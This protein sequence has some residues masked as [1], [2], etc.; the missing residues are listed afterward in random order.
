MRPATRW[1]A[2][3]RHWSARISGTPAEIAASIRAYGEQG[4]SHLQLYPVPNTLA[5]L[6]T[7]APILDELQ[8]A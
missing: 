8:R 2:I 1:G 4:V 7:L 6:E 5:T 3:R